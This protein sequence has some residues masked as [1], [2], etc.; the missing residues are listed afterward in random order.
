[1]QSMEV[2]R[3]FMYFQIKK[4]DNQYNY[5]IIN[6]YNNLQFKIRNS[7]ENLKIKFWMYF[8]ICFFSFAEMFAFWVFMCSK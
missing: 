2:V 4:K 7:N 1:M 5:Y 3:Y 8:A 6:N